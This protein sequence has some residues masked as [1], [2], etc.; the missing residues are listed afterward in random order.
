MVVGH[1]SQAVRKEFDLIGAKTTVSAQG[2][3]VVR[4]IPE[5]A[6]QS[7]NV[8]LV[9]LAACRLTAQHNAV[10]GRIFSQRVP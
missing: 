10:R 2:E 5:R 9:G 8:G 7:R 6:D 4:S 3:G 1:D